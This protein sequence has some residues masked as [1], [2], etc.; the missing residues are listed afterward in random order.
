M[1]NPKQI[2]IFGGTGFIGRHLVRRLA[3]TGAVIRV[4]TRDAEKAL[5]L[6]PM[7][8]VGQIVPVACNIRSDAS[9]AA[10]I[11]HSDMVVNLLGILFEKG[12]NSFQ[13]VHVETAARIARMAKEAGATQ[14]L[15]MSALGADENA[16]AHYAQSKAAGEKAVRTF[17][18]NAAIFRPSIV[19]GPE[20]NFFN[21]FAAMAQIAPALPLIGGGNTKFQPVYVGDVADAMVAASC[22]GKAQGQVFELG[23]PQIYTFRELLELMLRIVGRKTCLINLPWELA[24]FKAT[25]LELLPTP[26]LTR[27]QVTTLQR[28]AVVSNGAKTLKDLGVNPTAL[29]VILPGYLERFYST[30]RKLEEKRG[31]P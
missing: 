17:F 28:D 7:G 20:D 4:A 13:C 10:A 24:K 29:E 25:F 12:R 14:L 16:P 31:A 27:D 18:P 21:K 1:A 8:D 19:F 26:P 11:G 15:H 30:A 3:K 9:V 5:L 22:D 2:T 23:G 6:K